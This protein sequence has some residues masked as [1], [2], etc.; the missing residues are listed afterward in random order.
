MKKDPRVHPAIVPMEK[1]EDYRIR[2]IANAVA[3]RAGHDKADYVIF[4]T[5]DKLVHMDR[6][7]GRVIVMIKTKIGYN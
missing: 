5:E 1:I 4:G 6:I 2:G 7:Y 3:I